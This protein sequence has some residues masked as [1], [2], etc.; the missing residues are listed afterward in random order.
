MNAKSQANN[1]F[2][3]SDQQLEKLTE[4]VQLVQ[5]QDD[6][7]TEGDTRQAIEGVIND[8]E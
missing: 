4:W 1:T 7:V 8:C 3:L 2:P 5:M 6:L